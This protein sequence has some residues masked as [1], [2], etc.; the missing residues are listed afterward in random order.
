MTSTVAPVLLARAQMQRV[1]K[2]R[3]DVYQ[4]LVLTGLPYMVTRPVHY[5]QVANGLIEQE[6]YRWFVENDR[7]GSKISR[8]SLERFTA[9]SRTLPELKRMMGA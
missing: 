2:E 1:Q 9:T 5:P 3:P 8:Q 4:A 7:I 6:T